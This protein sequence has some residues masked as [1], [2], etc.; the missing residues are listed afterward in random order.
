MVNCMWTDFD[1]PH[2]FVQKVTPSW[3]QQRTRYPLQV[4]VEQSSP[5][6]WHLTAMFRNAKYPPAERDRFFFLLEESLFRLCD[7]P[8]DLLWPAPNLPH[9]EDAQP[10]DEAVK[11][12]D[13]LRPTGL[14]DSHTRTCNVEKS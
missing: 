1:S 7:N 8:L 2:G 3:S 5:D 4:A 12:D 10:V 9:Q 13:L 6:V 11:T 14:P